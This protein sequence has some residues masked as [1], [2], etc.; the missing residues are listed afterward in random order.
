MA[1][2][3]LVLLHITI[4]LLGNGLQVR[5]ID[6]AETKLQLSNSKGPKITLP[7]DDLTE[8]QQ[9]AILDEGLEIEGQNS[10][11]MKQN[12]TETAN[13]QQDIESTRV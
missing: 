11:K 4:F 10:P 8:T 1:P 12:T 9:K 13:D 5:L 2:F 7:S 6:I 3:G